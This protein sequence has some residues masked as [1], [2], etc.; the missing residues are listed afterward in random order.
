M[1]DLLRVFVSSWLTAFACPTLTA[2]LVAQDVR[3]RVRDRNSVREH[4]RPLRGTSVT[5]SQAEALTLT[6]G[7]VSPRLVQSWIRAAGTIDKTNK[8]LSAS[9]SGAAAADIKVGQRVRAFPPSSKSSMYQAFVTRVTPRAGGVA[10]EASLASSGRQNTTLYVMEIVVER[11][12]FL[13]VPNEAI[14]EEGDNQI[15]YVQLQPGQYVPKEIHTGIQ[16]ELYTQV[17][18]G[19]KDGDQVVTFGSFFIDAEHK[20]KGTDQ[21][22]QTQPPR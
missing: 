19:V 20:L 14:I 13:S 21:G 5:E 16:G 11:G 9:V 7:G 6:V 3:E 8:V 15:V 4:T 17:L 1:K 2:P 22:P 12:P 10:V 18:D